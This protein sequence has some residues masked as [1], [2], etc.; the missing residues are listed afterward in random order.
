MSTIARLI[1]LVLLLLYKND[2]PVIA[3]M[4]IQATVENTIVLL[5]GILCAKIT[6]KAAKI[7]LAAHFQTA[8][9]SEAIFSHLFQVPYA[10]RS[11]HKVATLR[12]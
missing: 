10:E 9:N 2:Y 5:F 6:E 8:Q 1:C 3:V 4:A 12:S 7:G 11:F